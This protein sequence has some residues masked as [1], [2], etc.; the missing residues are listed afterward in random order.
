M[1]AKLRVT[2][3][4]RRAQPTGALKLQLTVPSGWEERSCRD[5]LL[6]PFLRELDKRFAGASAAAGEMSVLRVTS[7]R[8][9]ASDEYWMS[10]ELTRLRGCLGG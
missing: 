4:H 6:A 3:H 2:V 8:L 7:R 9:T 1:V 5:A 10:M